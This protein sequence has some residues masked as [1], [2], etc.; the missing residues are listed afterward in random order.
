MTMKMSAK[1]I[2]LWLIGGAL[3]MVAIRLVWISYVA[4]DNCVEAGGSWNATERSCQMAPPA[5]G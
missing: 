3:V 4:P 1:S 2:K 5:A